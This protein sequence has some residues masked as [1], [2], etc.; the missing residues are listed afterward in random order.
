MSGFGFFQLPWLTAAPSG[1]EVPPDAVHDHALVPIGDLELHA[2]DSVVDDVT[3]DTRYVNLHAT[4]MPLP[5]DTL[6]DKLLTFHRG[7]DADYENEHEEGLWLCMQ[8]V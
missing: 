6:H 5:S 7:G 3:Q 2:R 8:P 1:T 4:C